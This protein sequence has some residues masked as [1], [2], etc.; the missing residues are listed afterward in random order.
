MEQKEYGNAYAGKPSDHPEVKRRGDEIK[1]IV[2]TKEEIKHWC[3]VGQAVKWHLQNTKN[4]DFKA[5][6]T[7]DKINILK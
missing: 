7:D 2:L 4:S 5:K 3:E 6:N 1:A